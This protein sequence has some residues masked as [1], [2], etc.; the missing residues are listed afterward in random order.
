ML[1]VS[2]VACEGPSPGLENQWRR[3]M[4]ARQQYEM[5]TAERYRRLSSCEAV[6]MVYRAEQA[7]YNT[8]LQAKGPTIAR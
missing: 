5:C 4:D 7:R 2:M 6:L 3:M 8:A 1:A